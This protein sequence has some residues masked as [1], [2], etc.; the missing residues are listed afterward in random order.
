ML[1]I[2]FKCGKFIIDIVGRVDLFSTCEIIYR[3]GE[4]YE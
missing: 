4:Y 2:K 3:S 1:K